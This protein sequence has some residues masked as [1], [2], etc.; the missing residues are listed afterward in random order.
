[1]GIRVFHY[2]KYTRKTPKIKIYGGHIMSN[3]ILTIKEAA[4]IL[5]ISKSKLYELAKDGLVPN[6]KLGGRIVIPENQL[7]A[8][9]DNATTGGAL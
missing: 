9:I 4:E 1:M 7:M 3:N 6:I 8:W 2:V 5:R